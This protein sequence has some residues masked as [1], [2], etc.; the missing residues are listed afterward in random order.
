MGAPCA[1]LYAAEGNGFHIEQAQENASIP[2]TRPSLQPRE[3]L[4]YTAK[5]YG[6]ALSTHIAGFLA[7]SPDWNTQEGKGKV[8]L[9]I[10]IDADGNL[11]G[12]GTQEDPP[13][14]IA[15]HLLDL[16]PLANP[17]PPLPQDMLKNGDHGRF[18]FVIPMHLGSKQGKDG[19]PVHTMTFEKVQTIPRHKMPSAELFQHDTQ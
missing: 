10:V 1:H 2:S 7:A 15:E 16:L 3:K 13:N 17:F 11:Y 4:P 14:P 9:M 8:E 18:G 6:K 19:K 5:T 12:E